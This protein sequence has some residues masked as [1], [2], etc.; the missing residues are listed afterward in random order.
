MY[1]FPA[2]PI[3]GDE[4]TPPVGG[5]TYVW[6]PPR[7]LVKGIPPESG[8]SSGGGVEE[9]PLDGYLYGRSNA[10]WEPFSIPATDWNSITGKP[11]TFPPTVP[12]AWTNV[13]GKP[14]TYPPTLPIA[15]ADVGGKPTTFPPTVPIAWTDVSGK[16]TTYPPTLPIPQSAVTNLTSD[17]ANLNSGKENTIVGGNVG[18]YWRGDKTWQTLPA[19]PPSEPPITAGTSSQFWR[20]DKTWQALDKTT[21]GLTNVDNTSDASKPVSTAQQTA[22]NGRVSDTGDVMTGPL[23]L[24]ADPTLALQAATKQYVDNSIASLPPSGIEEA[25]SD[26]RYYMRRNAG[27]T[28]GIP[29]APQDGKYYV[30]KDGNWVEIP[31]PPA[32]PWTYDV[33]GDAIFSSAG[34]VKVRIK[35]TGL[36]LTKDD[37]EIFSVSV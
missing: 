20:G 4:Y 37:I 33:N 9:A 2:N 18:Q 6:K 28:P 10:A 3:D 26:N 11:S 35:P 27:W 23:V 16:P 7:W 30:R 21:V 29:D 34:N 17:L 31:P 5:Q 14:L 1:D 36:I 12:I 32:T 15:W 19:I 25:P 22:I 8:A 24:P 13:S